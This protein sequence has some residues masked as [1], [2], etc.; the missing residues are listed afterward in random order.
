MGA[1]RNGEYFSVL[2]PMEKELFLF[3]FPY[4]KKLSHPLD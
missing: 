2:I 4:G 3:I 1:V